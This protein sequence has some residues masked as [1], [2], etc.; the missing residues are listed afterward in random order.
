ML[1]Q[2]TQNYLVSPKKL[3]PVAYPYPHGYDH[4]VKCGFHDGSLRHTTE[5]YKAFN[6]M[7]KEMIDNKLLTF[8]RNG[9]RMDI[10]INMSCDVQSK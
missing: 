3:K 5:Y 8:K 7:V 4:N 10:S 2:L 6:T 9:S 1:P